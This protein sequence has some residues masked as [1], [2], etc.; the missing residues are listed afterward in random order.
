MATQPQAVLVRED[1]SEETLGVVPASEAVSPPGGV[2]G[3]LL[4]LR[5]PYGPAL[6]PADD[7]RADG[8]WRYRRLLPLGDDPIRYPL[9]VGGTPLVAPPAL[10]DLLGLPQLWL[11]DE[12][13][14]PSASNKDRATALVLEI[15]M[16]LGATRVSCASTGNVAVSL[17]IGAAAAGLEAVTFVAAAA[18]ADSKLRLMLEAGATVVKVRGGYDAAF[19]LSRSAARAFGWVDRNTGVNPVTVDAKKTV[20]LEIWEQLGR[21]VPDAVIVPVGDGPTLN[22]M[23][24]GFREIV[25]CGGANRVPRLIGVQAAAC[26]PIKRAWERGGAIEPTEPS[27]IADGIAVGRPIAGARAVQDV[28]ESGGAFVAVTDDEMMAA[29]RLLSTRTGLLVEPAGAASL[30]GLRAATR[31]GLVEPGE[32]VVALITGSSLKAPHVLE[33]HGRVIEVEPDLDALQDRLG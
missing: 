10:R 11:K 26:Q 18:V 33:G 1:G 20:A 27:T 24:K 19:E 3:G 22:G 6:L 9:H 23:A 32:R 29:K 15:A 14:G 21:Q 30:A 7:W 25:A 13:R 31:S 2:G 12:T 8:M 17:A 4:D 16:T 28:R 5:Y